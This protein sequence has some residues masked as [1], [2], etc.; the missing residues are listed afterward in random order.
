MKI[1]TRVLAVSAIVAAA[2]ACTPPPEP[3]AF[4]ECSTLDG[5][6]EVSPGLTNDPAPQTYDLDDTTA[7]S[8]CTDTTGAGITGGTIEGASLVFPDASC[9]GSGEAAGSGMIRWSDGS[10]S[11]FTGKAVPVVETGAVRYFV[12]VRTGALEGAMGS[13]D[14]FVSVTE[15]DCTTGITGE[16]ITGGPL[17]LAMS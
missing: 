17:T 16:D 10:V 7:L 2:A 4:L 15:G 6:L 5:S 11:A 8:G 13:V 3:E 1:I 12:H 14:V 9:F